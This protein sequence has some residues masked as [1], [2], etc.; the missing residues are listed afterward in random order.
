M[1]RARTPHRAREEIT[2]L[3]NQSALATQA[4]I[5]FILATKFDTALNCVVIS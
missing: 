3:P 2:S 5:L 4:I 1:E